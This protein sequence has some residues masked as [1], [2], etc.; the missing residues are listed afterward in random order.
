MEHTI[1]GAIKLFS[2]DLMF[3]QPWLWRPVT[4]GMWRRVTWKKFTDVP[5]EYTAIIFRVYE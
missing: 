2:L 1:K 5:K 3:P 4:S